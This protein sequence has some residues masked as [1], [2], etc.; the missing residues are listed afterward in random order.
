MFYSTPHALDLHRV[1]VYDQ[2]TIAAGFCTM[3][4]PVLDVEDGDQM[5]QKRMDLADLEN[6]ET[7]GESISS[8]HNGLVKL[9]IFHV[10]IWSVVGVDDEC[11]RVL[12]HTVLVYHINDISLVLRWEPSLYAV[13]M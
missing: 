4:V 7:V 10:Y 2:S 6:Q 1:G 11:I 12:D 3:G 13:Q 9:S 5:V 8:S